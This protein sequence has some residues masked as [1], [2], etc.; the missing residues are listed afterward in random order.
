MENFL[1]TLPKILFLKFFFFS[2]NRFFFFF[3]IANYHH[4]GKLNKFYQFSCFFDASS[5]DQY[6]EYSTEI[7]NFIFMNFFVNEEERKQFS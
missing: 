4:L 7:Q 3:S 5:S 2:F 6:A 1:S